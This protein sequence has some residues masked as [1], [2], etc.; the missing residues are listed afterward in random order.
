MKI[1]GIQSHILATSHSYHTFSDLPT[2]LIHVIL[3]YYAYS[4]RDLIKFST[5]NKTCQQISDHS[6]LWL[7]VKLM[8]YPSKQFLRLKRFQYF[9]NIPTSMNMN[10]LN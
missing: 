4:F 3:S 5:I 7:E 10:S 1:K 8:F 2:E 9:H 6:I